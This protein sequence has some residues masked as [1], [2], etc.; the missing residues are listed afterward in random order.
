MKTEPHKPEK[1]APSRPARLACWF[2]IYLLGNLVY[3]CICDGP[4]YDGRPWTAQAM[5]L[6]LAFF[7]WGLAMPFYSMLLRTGIDLTLGLFLLLAYSIYAIHLGLTLK[8]PKKRAFLLL[9]YS[10]IVLVSINIAGCKEVEKESRAFQTKSFQEEQE[11]DKERAKRKK[12]EQSVPEW[13]KPQN[14][15]Y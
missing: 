3:L 8:L 2:G 14:R 15:P 9:M 5:L 1:E 13:D 10:L 4:R 7:P 6:E 11:A 12:Q